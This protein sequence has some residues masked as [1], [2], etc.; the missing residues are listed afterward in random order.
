MKSPVI[1]KPLTLF[2]LLVLLSSSLVAQPLKTD[3]AVKIGGEDLIIANAL[4]LQPDGSVLLTCQFTE[5]IDADPGEGIQWVTSAGNYDALVLK[6]TAEGEFVWA[7]RYGAEGY[8]EAWDMT[9]DPDGNIF[10]TGVFG[11]L[12]DFNPGG[13]VANLMSEGGS[14]IYLL[15]LNPDGE[16]LWAKHFGGPQGDGPGSV[17]RDAS[18]QIYLTGYFSNTADFDP[19]PGTFPLTSESGAD[20][21]VLKLSAAGNPVWVKRLGGTGNDFGYRALPDAAGNVYTMGIFQG[22]AD[23]DPGT[24]NQI[25]TSRG[26]NDIFISK[27]NAT[28]NYVWV[29]HLGGPGGDLSQ[30]MYLD[31]DGNLI[32]TG[33][34]DD[35]FDVDPSNNDLLFQP[36]GAAD[37]FVLKVT[38]Q[39]QM[40]WARQISATGQAITERCAMLPDQAVL[41]TGRFSGDLHVTAGDSASF[42]PI[43]SAGGQDIFWIKYDAEGLPLWAATIGGEMNDGGG[44]YFALATD[45]IGSIFTAGWVRYAIDFD[46]GPDEL[47]LPESEAFE[48]FLSR[49]RE[50]TS[51]TDAPAGLMPVHIWPNPSSGPVTVDCRAI[52][53]PLAFRL[54]DGTGR[55][56]REGYLQAGGLQTLELPANDGV[57]FLHLRDDRGR[58]HIQRIVRLAR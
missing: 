4:A 25:R 26:G 49:M 5:T 58:Q 34:F 28:G 38:P 20:V 14:D 47:I 9:T 41:V 50:V 6:L 29:R 2:C 3:W 48:V 51:A 19:G 36:M 18:G 23:F 44:T 24:T 15:K 32:L 13:G 31:E 12:V 46:P 45:T 54:L 17:A 27:L 43:P 52:A 40:A 16:Y 57:W 10:I 22:E 30:D 42:P 21:F 35:T 55:V 7:K 53:Q 8:D 33:F 11:G 56:A 1:M 39:G 37:G